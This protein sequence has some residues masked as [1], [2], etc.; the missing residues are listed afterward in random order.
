M[1]GTTRTVAVAAVSAAALLAAGC[2]SGSSTPS[3]ST[4]TSASAKAGGAITVHGCT[5][6]N[7]FIPANT[8]ETCGGNVLDAVVSK[9]VRY[10]PDTAAPEMD[11]A[12]K[13]ESSDNQTFKVTL[14][15]GYMF[16]DGTEA[17]SYTHLTLPTK[18]IV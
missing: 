16:S 11:I 5:P 2:S 1:R 10:N 17:V 15:K 7:P 8:N 9:L 4:S 12:E 6:Q 18:R 14:N 13:I 3:A